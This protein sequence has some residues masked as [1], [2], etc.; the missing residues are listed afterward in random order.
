MV[1]TEANSV[2]ERRDLAEYIGSNGSRLPCCGGL[3]KMRG[4]DGFNDSRSSPKY[5]NTLH[6]GRAGS[7]EHG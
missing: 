3:R 7:L 4:H 2:G 5:H 1:K 6:F